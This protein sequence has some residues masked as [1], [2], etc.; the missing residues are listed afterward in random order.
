MGTEAINVVARVGSWI[1]EWASRR[2]LEAK[3]QYLWRVLKALPPTIVVSTEGI[4]DG[5]GGNGLFRDAQQ[6]ESLLIEMRASGWPVEFDTVRKKWRLASPEP[7]I[8]RFARR[9]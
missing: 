1:Q 6:I 3:R 5:A 4:M 7:S 2:S 8:A 9:W